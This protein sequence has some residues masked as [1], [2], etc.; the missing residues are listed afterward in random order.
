MSKR[1]RGIALMVSLAGLGL[2]LSALISFL[3][4][5]VNN[6]LP[7]D[8]GQT[9]QEFYLAVGRAYSQGF[10]VGFFLCFFLGTMAL[11]VGSRLR[12]RRAGAAAGRS[13]TQGPRRVQQQEG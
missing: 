7:W 9:A 1:D 13:V 12:E 4:T 3:T 11:A 10:A 5:V 2:C 6:G 8:S